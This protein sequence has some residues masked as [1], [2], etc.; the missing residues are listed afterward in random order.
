MILLYLEDFTPPEKN[1]FPFIFFQVTGPAQVVR[2][3]NQ[4]NH[5]WGLSTFLW[6]H[7]LEHSLSLTDPNLS[8]EQLWYDTR[9]VIEHLTSLS[10]GLYTPSSK[11]DL[12]LLLLDSYHFGGGVWLLQRTHL[13]Y[14]SDF[15]TPVYFSISVTDN[16]SKT[17]FVFLDNCFQSFLG[18]GDT[19]SRQI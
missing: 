19:H 6:D 12:T 5:L 18:Q 1:Y 10:K 16:M 13:N 3:T 7:F 4:W 2:S 17:M 15:N 14:Y 9:T 8:E 11:T